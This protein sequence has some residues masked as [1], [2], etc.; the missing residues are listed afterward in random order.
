MGRAC[1]PEGRQPLGQ[2]LLKLEATGFGFGPLAGLGALAKVVA[3]HLPA[4]PLR[5][6]APSAGAVLREFAA[7]S[8]AG[9]DGK[10]HRAPTSDSEIARR[11]EVGQTGRNVQITYK[12][13]RPSCL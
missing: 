4:D 9:K 12:T 5:T 3:V 10:Q 1:G 13:A 11:T 2:S 7:G 8:M 6:V